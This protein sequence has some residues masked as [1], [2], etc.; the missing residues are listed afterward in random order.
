MIHSTPRPL[1]L[2]LCN[3][4]GDADRNDDWGKCHHADKKIY[5]PLMYHEASMSAIRGEDN[6]NLVTKVFYLLLDFFLLCFPYLLARLYITIFS[7]I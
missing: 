6:G 5:S 3:P 2:Q 1:T 4:C 7:G